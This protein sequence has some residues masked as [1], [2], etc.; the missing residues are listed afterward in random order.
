MDGGANGKADWD[1]MA[2]AFPGADAGVFPM[3]DQTFEFL[4]GRAATQSNLQSPMDSPSPYGSALTTLS[5]D[6]MMASPSA[7]D[8]SYLVSWPEARAACCTLTP[9][10]PFTF[11]PPGLQTDPTTGAPLCLR[12]SQPQA[13]LKYEFRGPQETS[14]VSGFA[15][16]MDSIYPNTGQLA[17]GGPFFPNNTHMHAQPHVEYPCRDTDYDQAP[18]PATPARRHEGPPPQTYHQ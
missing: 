4:N 16:L 3:G 1:M 15:G 2:E 9:R 11:K 7:S 8:E 5:P 17:A 6:A 18:A 12:P 10:Q 14:A 13:A